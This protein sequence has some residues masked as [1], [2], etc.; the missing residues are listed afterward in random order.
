MPAHS[1]YAPVILRFRS[2]GI[3]LKDASLRYYNTMLNNPALQKWLQDA[4][5]ETWRI[6]RYED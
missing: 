3:P 4:A 1:L 6:Q 5:Q 2:Y